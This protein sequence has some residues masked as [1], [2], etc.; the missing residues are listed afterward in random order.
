MDTRIKIIK[1]NRRAE[2]SKSQVNQVSNSTNA[3]AAETKT[4]DMVN[5]VKSWIAELKDRKRIQPHSFS[6]LPVVAL[7]PIPVNAGTTRNRR[8]L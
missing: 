6:P 7:S 2:D 5:T 8:I 4:R 3:R 1:Q